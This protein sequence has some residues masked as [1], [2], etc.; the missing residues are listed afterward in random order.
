MTE[1]ELQAL[2]Q[3][4]GLTLKQKWQHP[5][6]SNVKLSQEEKLELVYRQ[7]AR[8]QSRAKYQPQKYLSPLKWTKLRE[9]QTV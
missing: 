7:D 9:D 3:K 4:L 5:P 8:L 1:S 2:A 6:C